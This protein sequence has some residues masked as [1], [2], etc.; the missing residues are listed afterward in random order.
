MSADNFIAIRKTD[1]DR[2]FVS[3]EFASDDRIQP[4]V[5]VDDLPEHR[6]GQIYRSHSAAL[7]FAWDW[8]EREMIVEYGVED[9]TGE[10]LELVCPHCGGEL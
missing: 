5:K 7:D 4:I 1:D 9:M 10:R 3:M 8:Y 6:L 2:Y